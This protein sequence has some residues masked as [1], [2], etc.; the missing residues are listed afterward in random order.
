MK[1]W[2]VTNGCRP[3]EK[4]QPS[5]LK[6]MTLFIIA[7]EVRKA[8]W[9]RRSMSPICSQRYNSIPQRSEYDYGNRRRKILKKKSTTWANAFTSFLAIQDNT[10]SGIK[11]ITH[12]WCHSRYYI[13]C[14][15]L[16]ELFPKIFFVV[17]FYL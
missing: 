8:N 12:E 14:P 16:E 15:I 3:A 10:W 4:K 1:L 9:S 2:E 6:Q 7:E 11:Q 13:N 17:F 5:Y